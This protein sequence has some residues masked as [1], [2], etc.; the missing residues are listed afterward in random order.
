MS[1]STSGTSTLADVTKAIGG[2]LGPGAKIGLEL[3]GTLPVPLP[4]RSCGCDCEIPPPCWMPQPLD[5]IRSRVC[6]G[7]KGVLR[8]TLTNCDMTPRT[9][10]VSATDGAVVAPATVTLGP[11]EQGLVVVTLEMPI[12]ALVGTTKTSVVWIKGCRLHCLRW[13]AVA[14]GAVTGCTAD[15]DVEDGPDLVHH[16]Y[17][18]FYCPRPCPEK[19]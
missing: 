10:A 7:G 3:L 15:A 11:M 14:A 19:R 9:I 17:D 6:P 4:R 18:H 13:T 5:P 16:W 2:I 1:S 12:S 8:L